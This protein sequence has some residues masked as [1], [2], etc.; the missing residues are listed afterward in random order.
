MWLG[1][2]TGVAGALNTGLMLLVRAG[3]IACTQLRKEYLPAYAVLG[4]LGRLQLSVMARHS[5]ERGASLQA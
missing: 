4:F 1:H 5:I 2:N 3:P